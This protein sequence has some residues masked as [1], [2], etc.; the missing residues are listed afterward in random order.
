MGAAAGGIDLEAVRA[1]AEEVL[2]GLQRTVNARLNRFSRLAEMVLQV[3]ELERTPTRKIK[4]F[5]YQDDQPA[6][7]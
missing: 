5:L 6:T 7:T 4:R 3:E 2:K 1:Q